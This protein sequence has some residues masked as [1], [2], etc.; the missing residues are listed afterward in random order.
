MEPLTTPNNVIL[1]RKFELDWRSLDYPVLSQVPTYRP[2]SYS[3][4]IEDWFDQRA[5]GACVGFAFTH[6]LAARP[7]TVLGLSDEWARQVYFRAQRIDEWEGEG[8]SGT[9]VLAGAKICQEDGFYSS[10]YWGTTI[11]EIVLGLGYF[12]PCVFGLDWFEGMFET[13]AQG[14]IHPIGRLGGGHAI[15]GTAVK[16]VFKPTLTF[17]RQ[18]TWADV[19]LTKSYI[20]LRNSWGRSWGQDGNCKLSLAALDFLLK[21]NGDCCFPKR[22]SKTS[23]V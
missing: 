18:R 10:Y 13:D 7:Q 9:S 1:D 8:Y 5:E 15:V 17:W 2:R 12:G 20:T 21:R 4:R 11:E 6:E 23:L 22:T 14:F 16:I 3:W 19:D